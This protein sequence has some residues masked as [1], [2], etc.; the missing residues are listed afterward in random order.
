MYPAYQI[1]YVKAGDDTKQVAADVNRAIEQMNRALL[2]IYT[3]L[4]TGV[5]SGTALTTYAFAGTP[6]INGVGFTGTSNIVVVDS[7]KVPSTREV[8]GY[9]LA[10]DV[11]LVPWDIGFDNF[12]SSPALSSTGYIA[13]TISGLSYGVFAKVL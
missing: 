9:A 6:T 7:T 13:V 11:N 1:P 4:N 12:T 3:R 8:N 2:D 5:F 10:S